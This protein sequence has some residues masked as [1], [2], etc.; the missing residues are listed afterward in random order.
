MN[1]NPVA[2]L[3]PAHSPVGGSTA[4]RTVN[5]P[6]WVSRVADMP[7]EGE[8]PFAA[9]GTLLHERAE[10]AVI[11]WLERSNASFDT[12]DL[13]DEQVRAV[14]QCVEYTLA[15]YE[16]MRDPQHLYTE[17][18]VSMPDLHE[19]FYGTVDVVLV[20]KGELHIID[21][22]FGRGV[23][24]DAEYDGRL[25]RQLGYY[26]LG[27]LRALKDEQRQH[28][29]QIKCTIVQPRLGGVKSAFVDWSELATLSRE[30]VEAVH[31][32]YSD[33]PPA[34]A[35]K[36]CRFCRAKPTCPEHV[37]DIH[38]RAKL[39]FIKAGG[40]PDQLPLTELAD[41][42]EDAHVIESWVSAVKAYALTEIDFNN[43]VI[44]GWESA[45]KRPVRK[46]RDEAKALSELTARTNE[47]TA[48][49]FAPP[50]LRTPAQVEQLI[51]RNKLDI[52]LDGLTFSES[53]GSKLVRTGGA[54][55][56]L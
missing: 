22:K 50:K 16:A 13:T 38:E 55:D 33:N 52:T 35:G 31:L 51:K 2:V 48:Q 25:N 23:E 26:T 49:D 54:D 47:L 39:D 43:A 30:L 14:G 45:P 17:M 20:G 34:K 6:A 12:D 18:R 41:L 11:N 29:D 4:E 44:P 3:K 21:Y 10:Q 19:H 8:S 27:V 28:I 24:V 42:L 46:W 9:E 5:C 32:A 53:S 15:S 1:D 40:T 36:W 37:A 56:G 7:P